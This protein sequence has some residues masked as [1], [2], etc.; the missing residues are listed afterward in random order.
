MALTVEKVLNDACMLITRLK[1]QDHQADTLISTTQVLNKRIEAMKLY[2]DDITELNEMAKHRPRSTLVMGIAQENRQIRELQQEKRELQMALEEHQSALQLIMHKYRQHTMH[3]VHAN[4]VDTT[5]A[6]RQVRS[7]EEVCKLLD[8][9]EEMATVMQEA[10]RLDDQQAGKLQERITR[11]EVENQTLR[12][13]LE[14]CT[15]ANHP[16][17]GPDSDTEH[18]HASSSNNST[19]DSQKLQDSLTGAEGKS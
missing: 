14:I 5:I 6:Q 19:A 1:D 15:T 16:I 10:V 12:Q 17:L 11:L 18:D 13:L 8:K 2:Q 4:R 7:K 3:L 9:V